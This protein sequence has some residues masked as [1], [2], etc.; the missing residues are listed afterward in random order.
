GLYLC[1]MCQQPAL[2]VTQGSHKRKTYRCDNRQSGDGG[3]HVTR[4]A[5]S[6]DGFVEQVIVRKLS[7]PRVL[8]KLAK[9]NGSKVDV[10]ALQVEQAAIG[11]RKEEQAEL[12]AAGLI[13][14]A[15]LIAGTK[16]FADL[17][18]EIEAKLASAGRRTPLEPLLNRKGKS[19]PEVW[20]GP[21]GA[22]G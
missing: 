3:G 13:D 5:T 21:G 7:N 16:R 9:T 4:E 11:R 22:D 15:T 1:G 17:E 20:Y 14:R 18:Q 2:K 10:A 12:H 19:M 6:L 8:A